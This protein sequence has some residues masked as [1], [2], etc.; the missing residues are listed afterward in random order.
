M[1]VLY[2]GPYRQIDDDGQVA[3][4]FLN[5]LVGKYG[6]DSIVSR[7]IYIEPKGVIKKD[8]IFETEGTPF[9]NKKY[10]IFIQHMDPENVQYMPDIAKKH[11]VFLILD[12]VSNL[13][14][15]R[16]NLKAL[17]H[18]DKIILQS[19]KQKELLVN[20]IP[21]LKSKIEIFIPSINLQ[22]FNQICQQKYTFAN[23]VMSKKLYFI[24]NIDKDETIIK[25]IIFAIYSASSKLSVP[26]VCV[27]FLDFDNEPNISKIDNDI[28]RIRS[29]F[30]IGDNQR[31]ELFIFKHFSENELII[32]HGSCDIY[33]S[34]NENKISYLHEK[35]ASICGN[36]ILRI[37]DLSDCSVPC[38][39]I[40]HNFTYGIMQRH[41]STE[42]LISII[43]DVL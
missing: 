36:T 9:P 41:I 25:K 31:K 40:K 3:R 28:K 27:F 35:Y 13:G 17:S 30:G 19:E 6:K 1:N 34:L 23:Y 10:D 7:P 42:K 12:N 18:F 32:G 16:Y 43:K 38:K 15:I 26:P 24:G 37:D 2:L 39:N 14:L 22:Q 11:F 5:D 4:F 8:N 29:D 33:L 20:E 21:E